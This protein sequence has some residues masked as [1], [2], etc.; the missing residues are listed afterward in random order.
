MDPQ[1]WQRLQLLFTEIADLDVDARA[2]R[3]AVLAAEDPAL[4]DE[5]AAL[6]HADAATGPLDSPA[7]SP[8]PSSPTPTPPPIP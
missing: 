4:A 1:R 8:P 3:L 2:R 6:L 5:L 7:P